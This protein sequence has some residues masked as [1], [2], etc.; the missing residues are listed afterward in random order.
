M[1]YLW[2]TDGFLQDGSKAKFYEE[3]KLIKRKG[4]YSRTN[5]DAEESF[6]PFS[7]ATLPKTH[8]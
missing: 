2:P 1:D 8:I 3:V 7:S 5:N 4:K 6:F